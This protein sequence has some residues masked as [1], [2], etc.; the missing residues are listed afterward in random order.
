MTPEVESQSE[1][2]CAAGIVGLLRI[3]SIV[4]LA[5]QS[6]FTCAAGMVGLLRISLA[7]DVEF[8]S[9]FAGDSAANVPVVDVVTRFIPG[10]TPNLLPAQYWVLAVKPVH[11]VV[12]VHPNTAGNEEM[13][14]ET[15]EEVTWCVMP[16]IPEALKVDSRMLGAT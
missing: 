6:A 7:P 1:F 4:P 11:V 15:V 2:T 12:L 3:S 16:S 14:P 8:Q 9:A 13:P 5:F 10:T